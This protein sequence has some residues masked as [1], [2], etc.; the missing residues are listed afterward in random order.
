LGQLGLGPAV[1]GTNIATRILTNR[2]GAVAAGF[3]HSLF[4][5]AGTLWGMGYNNEGELGNGTTKN[6]FLPVEILSSRFDKATVFAGG[7]F[8]SQFA[9][10]NVLG[11]GGLWA[12]GSESFGQLGD[13]KDAN[14]AVT[15]PEL[16][17]GVDSGS[18]VLAVSVG[19][20]FG[21]FLKPDGSLWGM[22]DN[23]YG[24]LGAGSQPRFTNPV[25]IVPSGVTTIA[26]GS[27]H[28]IFIKS[29]GSLWGMGFDSL[30]QLG[31]GGVDGAFVGP[32]TPKQILPRGVTAIG[33]GS[34]HSLFIKSDGS[35]WGMGY[36][37]NGQLG[38]GTSSN[39][40]SP[41]LIAP[42]GVVTVAAGRFFSLFIR[43]DGSLWGMGDNASGQL[44]DNA[45]ANH[46][47]P[48][49]VVP[50]PPAL[51]VIPSGSNVLLLWPSNATGFQLEATT[52]LTPPI[53]WTQ[54][55][56][57]PILIGDMNEVVNPVTSPR[58]FYRLRL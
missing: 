28:T 41:I 1:T 55:S 7:M 5:V 36:N 54:V 30:G 19:Y 9:T 22:G 18:A 23:E 8:H 15:T 40:T 4:S 6:Q 45:Y 35:L 49:A 21:L 10:V 26:A 16:I 58:R 11:L 3:Y 27:A 14:K 39:R 44:G 34:D 43:S 38:D 37:H 33:A 17:F 51:T 31:D 20:E 52:D 42:S 50:S 24:Q 29:D 57:A 25:Q 32:H 56:P 46:Y 48:V 2:V 12:M 47:A 13:G 53:T